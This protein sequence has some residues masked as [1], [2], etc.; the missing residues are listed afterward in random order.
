MH[1]YHVQSSDS[2]CLESAVLSLEN[3][4]TITAI[5]LKLLV[6][7]PTE[8][9]C[10][11]RPPGKASQS[12]RLMGRTAAPIAEGTI[13]ILSLE[14][15]LPEHW[16]GVYG[17]KLL[18]VDGARRLERDSMPWGEFFAPDRLPHK[19]FSYLS[20]TTEFRGGG[21]EPAA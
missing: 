2:L 17:R 6:G 4:Q 18:F 10:L 8:S 14:E 3:G 21:L 20:D 12:I 11:Q 5:D 9:S 16:A 1:T 7:K 13:L 19:A 15:G